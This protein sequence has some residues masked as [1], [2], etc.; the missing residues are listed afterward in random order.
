MATCT[1]VSAV[2]AEA[3]SICAAQTSGIE[4]RKCG[5]GSFG[6][7]TVRFLVSLSLSLW[8]TTS[9]TTHEPFMHASINALLYD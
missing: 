7:H 3:E 4:S 8:Y 1:G 9:T 2:V 6:T 5:A